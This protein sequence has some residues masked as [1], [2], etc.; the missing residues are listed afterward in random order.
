M[1]ELA[2]VFREKMAGLR[3]DELAEVFREKI[4]GLVG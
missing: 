2:E 1:D 4:A 3:L